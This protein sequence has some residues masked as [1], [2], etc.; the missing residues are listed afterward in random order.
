M[1]EKHIEKNLADK[2]FGDLFV[3]HES[4]SKTKDPDVMTPVQH[5]HGE[6]VA[7]SDPGN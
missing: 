3:P 7:L 1:V 5:L 2:V 4:H 6:A